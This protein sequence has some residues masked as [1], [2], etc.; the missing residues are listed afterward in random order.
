MISVTSP[1]LPDGGTVFGHSR[2]YPRE[3]AESKT[4]TAFLK[5]LVQIAHGRFAPTPEGVFERPT[6]AHAEPRA[7]T[8]YFLIAALL[9]F[10]LDIW[11]RRRTWR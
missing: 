9:L 6:N 1:E 7:L 4:N 11:L 5:Q 3:H 2:S 10:P 8:D